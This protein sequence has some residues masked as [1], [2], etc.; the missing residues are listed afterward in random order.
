M[1]RSISSYLA[2]GL[3]SCA[4][5]LGASTSLLAQSHAVAKAEIPFAF[6]VGS[7]VMPAGTYIF[8]QDSQHIMQLHGRTADAHALSAVRP[9]TG[10]KAPKVGLITFNKY[11]DHYFL[12]S[13]STADST[14]AYQCP[15]T[16]QEKELIRE[17]KANQVAV[18]VMP[19][20]H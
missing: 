9:E 4:L 18:N 10:V 14:T 6:Q 2:S 19:T 8:S 7:K 11:G 5:S 3:V 12:Q 13:I 16:K 20:L 1:K 17:L 15:T